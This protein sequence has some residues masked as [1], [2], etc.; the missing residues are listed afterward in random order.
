MGLG[1]RLPICSFS[2]NRKVSHYSKMKNF[3]SLAV[4]FLSA[5]CASACCA[6]NNYR[7]FPMGEEDGTVLFLEFRF[8]RFCRDNRE[9]ATRKIQN[10]YWIHGAVNLVKWA[11]DSVQFIEN[12]DTVNFKEC[13]CRGYEEQYAKSTYEKQVAEYYHQTRKRIRAMTS[14][15]PIRPVSI[16]CNETTQI[17]K[18]STASTFYYNIKYRTW[19]NIDLTRWD[20][21]SCYPSKVAE[22][23]RY[24]SENFSIEVVRLSCQDVDP[25]AV[26]YRKRPFKKLK[27]AFWKEK[28]TWHGISRDLVRVEFVG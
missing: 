22:F 27:T 23:R 7:L 12:I 9:S 24:E 5:H 28:A 16:L 4:L 14:F 3:L 13:D 21:I 6:E 20:I 17:D 26:R 25:K 2:T 10:S 18:S 11:G 8:S 15:K 1:D 19:L